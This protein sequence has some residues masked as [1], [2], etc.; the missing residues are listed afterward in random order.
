MEPYTLYTLAANVHSVKKC[1][2][3]HEK[4]NPEPIKMMLDG[5]WR[6]LKT[7]ECPT[8]REVTEL[9]FKFSD[10]HS[11]FLKFEGWN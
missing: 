5:W 9:S 8:W 10:G 3:A 1:F 4:M 11:E 6:H 2:F 7:L